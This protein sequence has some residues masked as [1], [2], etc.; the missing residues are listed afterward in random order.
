MFESKYDSVSLEC[1]L[2]AGAI[3]SYL[4][5]YLFL[6]RTAD[7]VICPCLNSRNAINFQHFK[8]YDQDKCKTN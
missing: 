5:W 2:A 4:P 3:T 8:I 6:L 7:S 1:S